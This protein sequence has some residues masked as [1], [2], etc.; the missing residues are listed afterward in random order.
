[1][2]KAPTDA[3]HQDN[4]DQTSRV[5]TP[6]KANRGAQ[7]KLITW[8]DEKNAHLII[9][10]DHVCKQHAIKIPWDEVADLLNVGTTGGAIEQHITKLRNKRAAQGLPTH[11][12]TRTKRKAPAAATEPRPVQPATRGQKRRS[13]GRRN[14]GPVFNDGID[15]DD[16]SDPEAEF[17]APSSARK[18]KAKTGGAKRVKVETTPSEEYSWEEQ[19]PEEAEDEPQQLSIAAPG[20]T[21]QTG[22][23]SGRFPGPGTMNETQ[24]T[25]I[26]PSMLTHF[27]LQPAPSG[28][29]SHANYGSGS[30]LANPFYGL[31][32]NMPQQL[33]SFRAQDVYIPNFGDNMAGY[34]AWA[35]QPNTASSTFSSFG[36]FDDGSAGHVPS[37]YGPNPPGPNTD[38]SVEAYGENHSMFPLEGG[39]DDDDA[40]GMAAGHED[41]GMQHG[42][43][44]K[45]MDFGTH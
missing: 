19:T 8:T 37:A 31:N 9:L 25:A 27:Q 41:N 36:S 17:G 12:A 29:M 2:L 32:Y 39:D 24:V 16:A 7:R 35:A 3:N 23:Q 6:A 10:I 14:F 30:A 33:D 44:G 45:E 28:M 11:P 18:G 38:H 40:V 1:M 22:G 5:I 43:G 42:S 34:H 13:T 26:D 20:S 21:S 4:N 15:P